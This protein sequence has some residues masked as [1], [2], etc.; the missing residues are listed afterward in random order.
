MNDPLVLNEENISRI[1]SSFDQNFREYL[2]KYFKENPDSILGGSISLMIWGIIPYR[3]PSDIDIIKQV[4][5]LTEE[6]TIK[7]AERFTLSMNGNRF[8]VNMEDD[9]S[10]EDDKDSVVSRKHILYHNINMCIFSSIM[11]ERYEIITI[12]G[13]HIKISYPE[14]VI[15]AK[16]KYTEDMKKTTRAFKNNSKKFYKHMMDMFHYMN[17][18]YYM[19]K[20]NLIKNRINTNKLVDIILV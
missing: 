16:I 5:S 12:D 13:I 8:E 9:Y 20:N 18:D 6:K 3:T 2:F 4:E 19:I 10:E 15:S 11:N 14:N 17:S 1:F 7:R